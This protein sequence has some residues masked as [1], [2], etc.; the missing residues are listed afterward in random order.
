MDIIRF[1]QDQDKHLIGTDL[2]KS[3]VE[4]KLYSAV[5]YNLRLADMNSTKI[6]WNQ[7]YYDI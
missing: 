7:D 6:N 1:H 3:D 4:T 2:N 5:V